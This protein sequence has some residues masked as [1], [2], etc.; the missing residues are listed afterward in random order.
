MNDLRRDVVRGPAEGLGEDPVPD[1]LL[2]HPEVCDLD[3]SLLVE[4]D[5]VQ[6][7]VTVHHAQGME[8]NDSNSNLRRIETV[9]KIPKIIDPMK[10]I[11]SH[12][13]TS[14]YL[15]YNLTI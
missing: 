9:N 6:L 3:V 4:H 13:H 2:A 1:P 11:K 12:I 10:T 7:E 15:M 5:V 8:E 14:H